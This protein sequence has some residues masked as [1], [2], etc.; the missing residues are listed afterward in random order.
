MA[1]LGW[2]LEEASAAHELHHWA[3]LRT[4]TRPDTR[5][6]DHFVAF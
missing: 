4:A 3:V 5:P 1:N 2:T 6:F